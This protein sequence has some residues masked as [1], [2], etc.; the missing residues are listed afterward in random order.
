MYNVN[1]VLLI[2]KYKTKFCQY[3]NRDVFF[4]IVMKNGSILSNFLIYFFKITI[5][6][7]SLHINFLTANRI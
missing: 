6:S 3:C 7:I 4:E 1:N 5:G 2:G